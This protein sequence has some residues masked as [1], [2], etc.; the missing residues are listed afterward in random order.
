MLG[1]RLR[2]AFTFACLAAC[3][4]CGGGDGGAP[5]SGASFAGAPYAVVASDSGRLRVELRTASGEA[6]ERGTNEVELT[7]LDASSSAPED[8][9]VLDV[10]PWMVAMG[11]GTSVVPSITPRG[12]GRYVITNLALYM[13]GRWELRTRLADGQDDHA[14][15]TLDVP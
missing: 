14:S 13:P 6:P 1:S 11:H 10:V 2:A 15:P 3:A 9:L 7:V 12:G 4:G 8:G 5:S